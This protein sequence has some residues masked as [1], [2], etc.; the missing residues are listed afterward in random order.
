MKMILMSYVIFVEIIFL[1]YK[2]GKMISFYLFVKL[3]ILKL[4]VIF[5]IYE[6]FEGL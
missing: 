4:N 2:E 6:N 3:V 5:V 1:E